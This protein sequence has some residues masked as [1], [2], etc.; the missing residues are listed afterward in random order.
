MKQ[1]LATL[2][3]LGLLV[4]PALAQ[5]QGVLG[6]PT[7]PQYVPQG[8]ATPP[9]AAPRAPVQQVGPSTASSTLGQSKPGKPTPVVR[10]PANSHAQKPKP[11]P[12]KAAIVGT[13]AAG[14]VV[15]GAVAVT[16]P[17]PPPAP[18]AE[19]PKPE[20]E[21]PDPN[22]GST[23]GAVLPRWAALR[24]DE[25]N[26]RTGPGTRYP[27]DWVYH[28]RDLPVQIQREFEAWRLIEDQDGVKGWVHSAT[29]AGRRGFVIKIGDQTLRKSAADDAPA[30][31]ILRAGVAGRL[32]SCAAK[33]AWC[34]VE[35]GGF[36]GWLKR[37]AIWGIFPDEVVN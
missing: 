23:T 36:R 6:A 2:C 31:A 13:A 22:K 29:L 11:K 26:L 30:V 34:E 28:R 20:A 24:S 7:K 12:G 4:C 18:V 8:K 5:P 32:R 19:P 3:V 35:A 15:G 37:D 9:V 16:K 25:V 33:A 27:I 14:A 1:T 17:K 21:K 10:A